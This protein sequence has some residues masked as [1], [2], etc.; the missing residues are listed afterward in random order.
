MNGSDK[1]GTV[2]RLNIAY[3]SSDTMEVDTPPS[4]QWV[5]YGVPISKE[6]HDWILENSHDK[7]IQE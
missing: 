1:T 2:K 6:L 3:V 7:N 4:Y 5:R